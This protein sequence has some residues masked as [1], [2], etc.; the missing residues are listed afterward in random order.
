MSSISSEPKESNDI[1]LW[2]IPFCEIENRIQTTSKQIEHSKT[3]IELSDLFP[4]CAIGYSR[5][6]LVLTF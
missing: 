3:I 6:R 5:A 2:D 4:W 1:E